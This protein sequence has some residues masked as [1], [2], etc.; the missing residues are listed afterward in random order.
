M[1]TESGL[2]T[3][4]ILER[5]KSVLWMKDLF[6]KAFVFSIPRLGKKKRKEK[7]I[8]GEKKTRM[9]KPGV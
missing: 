6:R 5:Q 3:L 2:L 4:E 7:E 1:A 8:V 9:E